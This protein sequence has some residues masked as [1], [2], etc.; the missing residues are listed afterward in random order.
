M[1]KEIEIKITKEEML[2][3]EELDNISGAGDFVDKYHHTLKKVNDTLSNIVKMLPKGRCFAED[4]KI[5]IP[6]GTKFIKDIKIGDEVISLD[7]NDK[8]II[9]KVIAVQPVFKE[10]IFKVEFSDG[11]IWNATDT[12]WFY[13]GNDDYASIIDTQGKTALT[14]NGQ[15]ATVVKVTDTGK[16]PEVY[17]FIVEGVNVFFVNG[18]AAEGYS[19]E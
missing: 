5:S 6:N 9:S 8:K 15:R 12:Q 1:M 2:N 7:K 3:M 17:D 19:E 10:R 4:A 11:T 13:C 18:I 14:E 16:T